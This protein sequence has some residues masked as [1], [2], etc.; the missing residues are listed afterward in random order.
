MEGT[1]DEIHHSIHA[2]PTLTEALS[3]AA[4]ATTG[5]AIHI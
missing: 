4:A 5:E 1:I 2:H 3:E